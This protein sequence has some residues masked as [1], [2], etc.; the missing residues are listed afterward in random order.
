L[1]FKVKGTKGPTLFRIF[2]EN[3]KWTSI[4][5]NLFQFKKRR[6]NCLLRVYCFVLSQIAQIPRSLLMMCGFFL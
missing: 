2:V 6:I 1:T 5:C 4:Q 3:G